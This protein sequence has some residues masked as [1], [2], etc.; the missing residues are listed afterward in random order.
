[1]TK[2]SVDAQRLEIRQIR[3]VDEAE[4]T[5]FECGDD[6]LNGFLRDDAL[7]LQKRNTVTTYLALYDGELGRLHLSDGRCSRTRDEGAQEPSL[8]PRRSS[9]STRAQRR[10]TCDDLGVPVYD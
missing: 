3:D 5:A 7:R 4:L 1:M 9:G 10:S 8:E 6:D 2:A